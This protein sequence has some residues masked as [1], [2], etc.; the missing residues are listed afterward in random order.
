MAVR[1][2]ALAQKAEYLWY[3]G[4]EG[5]PQKVRV[6]S[7][8]DGSWVG[9]G[10]AAAVELISLEGRSGRRALLSCCK[11]WRSQLCPASALL[12]AP[13]QPLS[14]CSGARDPIFLPC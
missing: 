2:S 8:T 11:S 14:S 6:P 12:A 7:L 13:A 1:V 10:A 3:D 4:Q 5:Q 9:R